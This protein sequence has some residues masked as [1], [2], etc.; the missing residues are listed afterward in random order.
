MSW[1]K[2]LQL[3][4]YFNMQL[5]DVVILQFFRLYE[6]AVQASEFEVA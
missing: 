4:E 5:T 6:K 2:E 3:Y 1:K